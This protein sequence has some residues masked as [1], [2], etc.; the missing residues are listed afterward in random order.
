MKRIVLAFDIERSGATPDFETISI[1]A[2]VVDQDFKKLDEFFVKGLFVGEEKTIFENR[3]WIEC[4]SKHPEQLE[5]LK[6]TGIS[7]KEVRHAEMIIGFQEFRKK[8]EL[9][10][11]V[12]DYNFELC[13][14]F[15]V[16]DGGFINQLIHEHVPEYHPIPYNARPKENGGPE[17]APFWE[18]TSMQRGLLMSVDPEFTSD[19]GLTDRIYELYDIPSC[20]DKEI[21]HD[22]LP[23]HDA[24]TIACDLQI[25]HGIRDGSIMKKTKQIID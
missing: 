10:A 16:Y 22:H 12:N 20:V 17:Y 19:W 25:L 4:W 15:N 11:K 2:S 21:A 7:T 14:D 9:Y 24:Y 13:S 6:Y 3:C 18:T 23:H 5:K 8:W 1:G